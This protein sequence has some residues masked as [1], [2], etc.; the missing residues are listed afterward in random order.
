ME[1]FYILSFASLILFFGALEGVLHEYKHLLILFDMQ[2]PKDF[3]K[4]KNKLK[5]AFKITSWLVGLILF[6]GGVF[7][8]YLLG[9]E[10]KTFFAIIIGQ[11]IFGLLLWTVI[12]H[13]VYPKMFGGDFIPALHE[14]E[15]KRF[16][17]SFK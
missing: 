5:R 8:L 16:L 15:E 2:N 14:G 1:L 13:K 9:I 3:D 12:I 6:F 10:W 17:I 7:T 11:S 4:H